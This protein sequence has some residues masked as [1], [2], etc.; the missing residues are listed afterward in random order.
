[1]DSTQTTTVKTL[2]ALVLTRKLSVADLQVRETLEGM[3]AP[4]LVTFV[5]VEAVRDVMEWKR[6][7][8]LSRF[9]S[10]SQQALKDGWLAEVVVNDD[11]AY[12]ATRYYNDEWETKIVRTVPAS[13]MEVGEDH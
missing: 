9:R 2:T 8:V 1:M 13:A 4:V 5:A 7:N 6:R 3:E 11:G 10:D 12:E